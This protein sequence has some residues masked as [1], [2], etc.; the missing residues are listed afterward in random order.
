[1]FTAITA[2]TREQLDDIFDAAGLYEADEAD[3]ACR[4]DDDAVEIRED[5]AG[6][7]M[8]GDTCLGFVVSSNAAARRLMAGI[9]SVLG[10]EEAGDIAP[11]VRTDSMGR[12]M[13]VYF[14]GLTLEQV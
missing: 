9:A 1:M 11:R 6:R 12:D 4:G 3:E 7:S 8:Y 13:I 10:A 2:I 5:Y 14:P